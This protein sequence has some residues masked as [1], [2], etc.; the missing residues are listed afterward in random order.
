MIAYLESRD[1][2]GIAD[3]VQKI[4][5]S[6]PSEADVLRLLLSKIRYQISLNGSF[7]NKFL[8]AFI[9]FANPSINHLYHFILIM[10]QSRTCF[11]EWDHNPKDNSLLQFL[12]LTTDQLL[13][14]LQSIDPYVL[15]EWDICAV[16]MVSAIRP[17]LSCIQEFS[18]KNS[19]RFPRLSKN[20]VFF[21]VQVLNPKSVIRIFLGS[22]L[23]TNEQI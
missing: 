7:W 16:W 15:L 5:Q 12:I 3:L 13:I 23:F 10:Y 11:D 20:I 4:S 21:I 8:S 22:F 6:A 2:V 14:G 1:S 17:D 19:N 18:F 9:S